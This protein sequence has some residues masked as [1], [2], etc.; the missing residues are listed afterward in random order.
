MLDSERSYTHE[1]CG[2]EEKEKEHFWCLNKGETQPLLYGILPNIREGMRDAKI[3]LQY[4]RN[5]QE[6]IIPMEFLSHCYL[7]IFERDDNFN[8]GSASE[9]NNVHQIDSYI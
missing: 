6:R 5:F 1:G 2:G 9:M 7:L 3:E 4:L 8:I